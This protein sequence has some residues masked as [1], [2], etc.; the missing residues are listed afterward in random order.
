MYGPNAMI[1]TE[2][3]KY[4]EVRVLPKLFDISTEMFRY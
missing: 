4:F 3:T 1:S 2:P